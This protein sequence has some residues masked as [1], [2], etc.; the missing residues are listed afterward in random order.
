MPISVS[1]GKSLGRATLRA[2]LLNAAAA[3]G[4]GEWVQLGGF[5]PCTVHFDFTGVATIEL[6]AH[7]S[8]TRPL[9]TDHGFVLNSTSTDN[10]IQIS[11]PYEWVKARVTSFT[12]GTVS[13]WLV[14]NEAQ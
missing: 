1:R 2:T 14:G 8:P 12:S 10:A 4:D 11:N 3:T 7:N 6:D 5:H 9:D 13:A